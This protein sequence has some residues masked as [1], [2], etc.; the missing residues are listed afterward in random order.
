MYTVGHFLLREGGPVT[1]DIF[2]DAVSNRYAL[3]MSSY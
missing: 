3:A 1:G 2:D